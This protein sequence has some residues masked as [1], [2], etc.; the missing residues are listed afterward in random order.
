MIVVANRFLIS[1]GFEEQF[2]QRFIAGQSYLK[3]MP[4]FIR[5]HLLRPIEGNYYVVMTYWQDIDTF[6]AWTE[7]EQFKA[8]H[9]RARVEGMYAGPNVFEMHQVVHTIE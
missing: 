6:K 9:A 4:G 8:R 7:S 3:E 5:N 2:E 1:E